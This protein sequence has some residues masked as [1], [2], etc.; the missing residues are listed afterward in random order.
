MRWTK[1]RTDLLLAASSEV[2]QKLSGYAVL[3][4]LARHLEKPVMGTLFFA[5]TLAALAAATTELGTSRF[6]VRAIAEN[7]DEALRRLGEVVALRLPLALGV[8]LLLGAAVLAVRPDLAVV[9][10][11]MSA[12]VM[13]TD[14]YY[15]FGAFFLG[16]RKVGLRIATGLCGPLLTIPLVAVAV[17]LRASLPAVLACFVAASGSGLA[18][19]VWVVRRRYGPIP[20]VW[21]AGAARRVARASLPFFALA[22]LGLA[23]FKVDTLLLFT[24]ASPAAVATYEAGYKLLE[25]SRAAVRPAMMVFFPVSTAFVA[26]RDWSGFA[27]VLRKLRI[28]VAALG[29]MV[30]VGMFATAGFLVPLFWGHRYGDTIGVLRVLALAVTPMY[31]GLVATFLAGS[32]R[33]ETAAAR[34]LAVSLVANVAL[35]LLAIPRLGAL[36]AA[37]CTV[38]TETGTALWLLLLIARTLCA[39]AAATSRID[40]GA[41]PEATELIT[42]V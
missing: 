37:W 36:G 34:V 33:L 21:D 27:T 29:V 13:L 6:L 3:M 9:V 18:L 41:P 23:H 31:L 40:P 32:L 42:T 7:P 20:I 26:R 8:L 28:A 16:L 11:L 5:A 38:A 14:L 10:V 22:T 25:A 19:T 15:S 12:A 17:A 30:C 4:I 1:I 24:L 35:N 39:E 2:L